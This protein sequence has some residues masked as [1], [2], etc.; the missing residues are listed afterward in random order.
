MT[1]LIFR[2]KWNG[3]RIILQSLKACEQKIVALYYPALPDMRNILCTL[4]LCN[5]N[6]ILSAKHFAPDMTSKTFNVRSRPTP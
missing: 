1:F 2:N 5:Y 6:V 3:A 4:L